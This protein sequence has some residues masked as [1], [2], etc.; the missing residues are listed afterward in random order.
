MQTA[1][2]PET[3]EYPTASNAAISSCRAC[4]N[5]GF[6]VGPAERRAVAV[7]AVIRAREHLRHAPLPQALQQM[8]ADGPCHI[9][10]KIVSP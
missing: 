5:R 9:A 8:V 4:T 2:R 6:A 10:S 7:D 1:A 3:F